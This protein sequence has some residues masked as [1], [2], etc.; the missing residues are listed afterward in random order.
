[1]F[2]IIPSQIIPSPAR[3]PVHSLCLCK[4]DSELL[5]G[6]D[7]GSVVIMNVVS[8]EIL[9]YFEVSLAVGKPILSLAVAQ[10]N[11]KYVLNYDQMYIYDSIW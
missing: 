7:N 1:M 5:A 9:R 4:D 10:V 2:T 3:A 8:G 11:E 6:L